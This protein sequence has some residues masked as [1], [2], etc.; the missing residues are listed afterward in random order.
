M[1]VCHVGFNKLNYLTSLLL[2]VTQCIISTSSLS[3]S[4]VLSHH[5]IYTCVAIDGDRLGSETRTRVP[6]PVAMLGLRTGDSDL[7]TAQLM[8]DTALFSITD[9]DFESINKCENQAHASNRYFRFTLLRMFAVVDFYPA[10]RNTSTTLRFQ[11]QGQV[12]RRTDRW[13]NDEQCLFV[14][15]A[16]HT[17][18]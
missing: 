2:T 9:A 5:D 1:C 4:T 16:K 17:N 8:I 3:D 18:V 6:I 13:T 15:A 14:H 10:Q 11:L 7:L 12:P